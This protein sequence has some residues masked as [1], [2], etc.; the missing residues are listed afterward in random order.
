MQPKTLNVVDQIVTPGNAIEQL[1]HFIGS[2]SPWDV[3]GIWHGAKLAWNGAHRERKSLLA[4]QKE[5]RFNETG[6]AFGG[7]ILGD[8]GFPRKKRNLRSS[9]LQ[10]EP[11]NS[12]DKDP[13]SRPL[14]VVNQ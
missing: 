11:T 12:Q 5:N 14:C 10:K 13:S 1:P 6:E 7:V 8:F 4:K 2:I 3:I 9:R